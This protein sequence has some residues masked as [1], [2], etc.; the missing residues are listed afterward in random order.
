VERDRTDHSAPAA[1]VVVA[2]INTPK[3][4]FYDLMNLVY[5]SCFFQ[6]EVLISKHF[7]LSN[8][9]LLL[10]MTYMTNYIAGIIPCIIY[11]KQNSVSALYCDNDRN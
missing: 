3:S 9:S 8:T 7:I 2:I 6:N 10:C 5:I 1:A 11:E 4:P